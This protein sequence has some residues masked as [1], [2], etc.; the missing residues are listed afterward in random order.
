MFLL[1]FYVT[2]ALGV[3]FL[4]S[5]L[6][7]VLLS[8]TPSFVANME[9]KRPAIGKRLRDLKVDIDKPLAAILSLNTVAHTIGAAGAGAQ[10]QVT[11]GEAWLTA[12]S[13]VLTLL[14]LV[15]SEIIPKTLGAVYWRQLTPFV[16]YVLP[17]LITLTYPLVLMSQW[18]SG[19]VAKKEKG[20][21][22]NREEFSALAQLL[23]NEGVFA[24]EESSVL[25]NL[26]RF[27]SLEGK[28]IMTPRTV[29]VG[30]KET[31]TVEEVVAQVEKLR[32]SRFPIWPDSTDNV[33]GLILKHDLLMALAHGEPTKTMGELRRDIFV[34][35]ATT[36]LPDLMN[37][38]LAHKDHFALL[39]GEFGGTAGIVTL[40]DIVETILG[41]EIV[42]EIDAVEDM[43][44]MARKTWE[45]R[46][47]SRGLVVDSP[48]AAEP[49]EATDPEAGSE[50][51][52]GAG[53]EDGSEEPD[54]EKASG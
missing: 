21:T 7:A 11:F 45:E 15:V 32:F 28:D 16:A 39:S 51:G 8:V 37:R 22:L 9:D 43:Q 35:P 30:F 23:V 13:A 4:C 27:R 19:L 5:V 53:P 26:L 2:L 1:V 18:F 44:K 34:L 12:F 24:S 38:M 47:R 40:E 41:M 36:K 25:T 42:D 29:L 6:E 48:E 52:S 50:E 54:S 20:P 17:W 3:S 10:A 31:D 46:A 33:S 49:S 14:I